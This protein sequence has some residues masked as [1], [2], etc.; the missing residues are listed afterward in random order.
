M[1]T[2][3]KVIWFENAKEQLDAVLLEVCE[4]LQLSPA[5]YQLANERY[6]TLNQVLERP[7]SPF[8]FFRPRI[9]AQ[10]SMPLGTTCKP[11]EGPHDLDFVLQLDAPHGQWHPLAALNALHNFL[12]NNETYRKMITMKNRVVRLSYADE[13]YMDILPAYT[14]VASG[15][16]C[17]LVP[18]RSRMALCSSNPEGFILWFHN[19]CFT[20]KR[21]LLEKA[22][23]LPPQQTVHEMEPLQLAVQLLKRWRDLAFEDP[24]IAISVVVTTLAGMHY[25]G[26]ESVSEALSK[27]LAGIVNAINLADLHGRR[28]VVRNPSNT[29]E[30]FAER[31]DANPGAYVAFKDGIRRLHRDWS[32]IIAG[33]RDTNKE[34]E[35]L[36]GEYVRTALIKRSQRLQEARKAGVLAV[37][38]TGAITGLGSGVTRIPQNV[39]HGDD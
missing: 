14:D 26:E 7:G 36:F 1:A 8:Q 20:R 13:F 19:K 18:D 32:A 6:S 28:I 30:D 11:V 22:K 25:G 38:S 39:F 31:W 24:C 27:I 33:G 5:R 12:A 9:F 34:L 2:A 15:G 3:R 29:L 16:T 10:G 37:G 23:P 35:R 21:L 4:E 17:I